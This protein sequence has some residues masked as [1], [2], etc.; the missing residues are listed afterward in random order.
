[1]SY[2]HLKPYFENQK[3]PLCAYSLSSILVWQSHLYWP[4]ADTEKN[5]IV[6]GLKFSEKMKDKEHLLLPV[7]NGKDASPKELR[8]IAQRFGFSQYWFV[9]ESYIRKMEENEVLRFFDIEKQTDFFDYIYRKKELEDLPG[10]RYAKKRNLINQFQKEYG[11]NTRI[12]KISRSNTEECIHFLELWCRERE[13]DKNPDEDLACEKQACI[14]A[15]ENIDN[16]DTMGIALR[17]HGTISAFGI[18]SSLTADM[19][20]LHF[21]KAFTR[22]KGLYQF[23]DKECAAR[24]FPGKAFI[25][26]ESDMGI[27]G[28][29]K[30]KKSYYPHH[31]EESFQ[32]TL[33]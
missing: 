24:L 16:L 5:R 21:E 7:Q 28:L 14:L 6:V 15:L 20:V 10:N 12:E 33:L 4:V 13:C 27:E 17:V 18:S 2:P 1:M 31:L 19:G 8:E 3:Y 26:K 9:P 30:A 25:N 23:L 11:N 22:I 32:L 29:A